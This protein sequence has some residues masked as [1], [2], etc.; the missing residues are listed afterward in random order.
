MPAPDPKNPPP[1]QPIPSKPPGRP[2][3]D[4]PDDGGDVPPQP[5]IRIAI[6]VGASDL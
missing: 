1:P 6:A 2:G 3:R 4:Q 5:R